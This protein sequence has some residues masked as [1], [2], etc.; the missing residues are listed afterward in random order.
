MYLAV[1]EPGAPGA[2]ERLLKAV[3]DGDAK[4]V[5]RLITNGGGKGKMG[6]KK[7]R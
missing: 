3:L 7:G 5:R 6:K 1:S 4:K 2:A